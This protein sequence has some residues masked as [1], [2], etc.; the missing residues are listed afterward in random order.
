MVQYMYNWSI[1]KKNELR[2]KHKWRKNDQKFSKSDKNYKLP[3]LRDQII[4]NKINT[5][6]HYN[7]NIKN[8]Q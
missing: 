1:T 4:S 6:A 7:Q 2:Q 8:Q 3:S 5:H